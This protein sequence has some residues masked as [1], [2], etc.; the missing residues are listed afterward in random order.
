MAFDRMLNSRKLGGPRRDGAPR[1]LWADEI[2]LLALNTFRG[3]EE[4]AM[5]YD[6]SKREEV[7]ILDLASDRDVWK[8]MVAKRLT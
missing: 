6:R 3:T 7:A 4:F 1:E 5:A 2:L 8:R